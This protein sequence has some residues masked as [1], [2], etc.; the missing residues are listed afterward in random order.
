[1]I[2]AFEEL[3]TTSVGENLISGF[4]MWGVNELADSAVVV[5]GRVMTKPGTQWGVGRAYRE[6]VKRMSDERGIEIPFPHMT[7]W[8]GEDR[9][10][11]AP[12]IR[13][14]N[15]PAPK[16]A[17]V[18]ATAEDGVRASEDRDVSNYGTREADGKPI[19]PDAVD[20]D[21]AGGGRG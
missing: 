8:F 3:K 1:M 9:D 12:P 7:V 2:A 6:I 16:A 17:I 4:D 21:S 13:M 15:N 20:I 19:P 5:R 14:R 18:D 10:G 11:K